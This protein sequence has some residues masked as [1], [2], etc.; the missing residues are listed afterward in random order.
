MLSSTH[1]F[2]MALLFFAGSLFLILA[3]LYQGHSPRQIAVKQYREPYGG[4]CRVGVEALID[5]RNLLRQNSLDHAYKCISQ[6]TGWFYHHAEDLDQEL[7]FTWFMAKAK[8]Q[9]MVAIRKWVEDGAINH[10][11]LEDIRDQTIRHLDAVIA[12]QKMEIAA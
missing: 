11:H 6:Q 1:E 3:V 4:G 5:L 2:L 9:R 7:V 8:I 12:Q 10:I